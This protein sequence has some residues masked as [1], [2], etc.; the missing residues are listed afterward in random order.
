LPALVA[1]GGFVFILFSRQNFA[2]ELKL[3]GIVAVSGLLVYFVRS[4][5]AARS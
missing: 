4:R 2:A 3:A 1:L 5:V